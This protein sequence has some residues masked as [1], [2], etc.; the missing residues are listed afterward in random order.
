VIEG[1]PPIQISK[2]EGE[3]T[4]VAIRLLKLATKS[5]ISNVKV[6]MAFDL[7][8]FIDCVLLL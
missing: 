6:F 1:V 5:V 3:A 8:L 4:G 2:E 7:K